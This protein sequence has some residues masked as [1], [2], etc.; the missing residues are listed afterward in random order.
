MPEGLTIAAI[1]PR[2]DPSDIFIAKRA[3]ALSQLPA[4]ARVGTSSV[5][6]KAQVLRLRPDSNVC[7][8]A[9]TS[10]PLGQAGGRRNGCDPAGHGRLERLGLGERVTSVLNPDEWLPSLAQGAVGIEIRTSDA[11]TASLT[12]A[13]ND[14]TASLELACERAFQAALDGT[15]RTPIAAWPASRANSFPFAAR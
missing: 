3:R 13:L 11:R 8:C 1:L 2:E 7:R 12:A 6:R 9:A 10:I 5:R 15:C 4:G 14:E